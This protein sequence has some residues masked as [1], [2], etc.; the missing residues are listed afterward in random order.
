MLSS[1]TRNIALGSAST[2][3]PSNSTFSSFGIEGD[4][5]SEPSAAAGGR[6]RG[7][8]IA[9]LVAALATLRAGLATLRGSTLVGVHRHATGGR[10]GRARRARG[11]GRRG[12][13]GR[14]VR[15]YRML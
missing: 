6:R 1:F 15:G 4:S 3:S 13:G 12:C 8:V 11:G 2:T 7:R 14:H 5:I 10:G 9:T